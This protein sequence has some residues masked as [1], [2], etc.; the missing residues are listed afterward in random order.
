MV[1]LLIYFEVNS[2]VAAATVGFSK[3]FISA[4][5]VILSSIEGELPPID[6]AFFMGLSIIGGLGLTAAIYYFVNKYKYL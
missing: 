5:T 1:P 2:R 4:A 3:L 6:L